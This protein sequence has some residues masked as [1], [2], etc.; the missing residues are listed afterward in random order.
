MVALLVSTGGWDA[1]G[2]LISSR[3]VRGRLS[4][5]KAAAATIVVPTQAISLHLVKVHVCDLDQRADVGGADQV[6]EH[7]GKAL[8]AGIGR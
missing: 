3:Q 2:W 1:A 6:R 8:R 7:L 4:D 5:A